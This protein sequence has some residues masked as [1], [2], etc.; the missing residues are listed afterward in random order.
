MKKIY[1]ACHYFSLVILLGR[2]G[3]AN[4]NFIVTKY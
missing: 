2:K 1:E 3:L 4:T